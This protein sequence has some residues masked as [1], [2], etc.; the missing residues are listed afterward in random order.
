[1][2]SPCPYRIGILA[3]D[4]TSAADGAGP[5]VDHG[6]PAVVGRAQ[7]PSADAAIVAVDSQSRSASAVQ[8][9]E[10]V[11]QLTAQLASRDILYKTCDS[12]LRGHVKAE[13]EAAFAASGRAT[14]VF[15][16]AFPDAGRTTVDGIQLVNGV[17][18]A[19]SVYSRDPVHPVR[20]SR[21]AEFVA[22]ISDA[23]LLDAATQD[24]LD[25]KVA[26]L[27]DPQSILWVGSPGMAIALARRCA[28]AK[29]APRTKIAPRG[30]ILIAIGSANP[31][32]HRQAGRVAAEADV[33]LLQA[34]RERTADPAAVLRAIAHDAVE[35]L[36]GARFGTVIAT[37]GETMEAIL[38][39]LKVRTFEILT[40]L[41]PGFPLGRA[42][43]TGGNALFIAMKAG[44]FGNDDTLVRAVA[45]LRQNIVKSGQLRA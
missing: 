21:L 38:D 2:S 1:M 34:P 43:L 11:A 31:V 42:A 35:R 36:R 12:T 10:R 13:M 9:A 7:L 22:A 44:G 5:F 41:E 4:L 33:T 26:A 17:P 14:L 32:S 28:W 16:P 19:E 30:D 8:G 45:Q 15:A 39:G 40:E 23:I 37:G 3:D 6:L 29:P 25:A 18:V 27:P 24:E 20:H